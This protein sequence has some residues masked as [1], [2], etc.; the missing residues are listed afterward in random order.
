MR[1][2]YLRTGINSGRA[3][4]TLPT[5]S[6]SLP[7]PAIPHYC[8]LHVVKCTLCASRLTLRPR[9][10]LLTNVQDLSY[11]YRALVRLIEVLHSLQPLTYWS[12]DR[13]IRPTVTIYLLGLPIPIFFYT[14][15]IQNRVQLIIAY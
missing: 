15:V 3:T 5:V 7:V 4:P 2:N 1:S 6:S 11:Q 13:C 14:Q 10:L 12:N 9:V 8:R